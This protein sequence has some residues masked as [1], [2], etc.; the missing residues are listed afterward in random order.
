[1]KADALK[2][3]DT[4]GIAASAS[5]FDRALFDQGIQNLKNLGFKIYYRD[6]IFKRERYLAGSDQ[7]RAEE[8]VELI[9]NPDIKAILFARGGYG[10]LRVLPYLDRKSIQSPPKII[11]GYSDITPLLIH[12]NQKYQW[13]TFYGPVVARDFSTSNPGTMKHFYEAVTKTVPLG[14]WIFDDVI[15]LKKG[16]CEGPLTGGCLSL[17]ASTLGTPYEINTDNKILFLEDTNEKPYEVDRML[18][19]LL[20][21]GKLK[22]V[23]GLL[24]GKFLNASEP[25]FYQETIN[26][27]LRDFRGPILFNF[28]VGHGEPKVTLPIGISAQ[29]NADEKKLLF[30]EAALKDS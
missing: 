23:R 2:L 17:V 11:L 15:C 27:V 21:A 16:V 9:E 24:F 3:G 26:D 30:T 13:T 28:P 12:L 22:H 25:L 19:Q 6:D 4:I 1:M 14:P 5:P 7:R 20:L 8:L 18:T 29:L 10:M